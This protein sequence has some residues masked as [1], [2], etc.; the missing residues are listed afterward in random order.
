MGEPIN[1]TLPTQVFL[2]NSSTHFKYPVFVEKAAGLVWTAGIARHGGLGKQETVVLE[3]LRLLAGV[4]TLFGRG[5]F[6]RDLF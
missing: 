4:L 6:A 5:R 1:I 2:K 3:R